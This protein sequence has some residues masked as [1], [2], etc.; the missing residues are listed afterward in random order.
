M[1]LALFK[2]R[3]EAGEVDETVRAHLR[4]CDECR[5]HYDHLEQ[6]ARAL[7]DDGAHEERERL[8]RS[9][10]V[11]QRGE[12]RTW[13][14]VAAAVAIAAVATFL[15]LPRGEPDTGLRGGGDPEGAPSSSLS[16][17]KNHDDC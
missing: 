1:S 17:G 3:I 12:Q 10:P 11:P 7:G 2:E 14:L 4:G 15:L 16:K 9:L 8:M 5:A 13:L 6:V